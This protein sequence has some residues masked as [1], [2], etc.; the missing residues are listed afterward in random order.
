MANKILI[1]ALVA[2]VALT[3]GAVAGIGTAFAGAN[4]G[5]GDGPGGRGPSHMVQ[6]L[7]T[8]KDGSVSKAEFQAR[9]DADFAAADANKDGTVSP[10]EMKAYHER[11]IEERKAEMEK[12]QFDRLD[13]NKDGKIS[14]DEFESAGMF[15]KLDKNKDGKISPDEMRWHGKGGRGGH[16]GHGWHGGPDGDAPDAPP[17]PPP[18]D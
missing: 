11:K 9:R 13:A 7:D 5:K 2:G 10:A 17:A 14:K 3:S 12:R 8:D 6:K 18:A 16:G 15:D 4:D 1:T